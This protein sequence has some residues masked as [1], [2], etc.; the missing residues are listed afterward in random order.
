MI[1]SMWLP[2]SFLEGGSSG[3]D[4]AC[5]RYV[6]VSSIEFSSCGYIARYPVDWTG[7]KGI[8]TLDLERQDWDCHIRSRS[9]GLGQTGTV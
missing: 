2:V 4:T 5:V 1:A 3:C 8:S 9:A 6:N 7:A